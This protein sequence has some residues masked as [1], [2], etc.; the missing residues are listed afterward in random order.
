MSCRLCSK[1]IYFDTN[2]SY[3][4]GG[5]G[6]TDYGGID[7]HNVG[8][9]ICPNCGEIK[10]PKELQGEEKEKFVFDFLA[11]VIL[12]N[13][14]QVNDPMKLMRN[15]VPN[16]LEVSKITNIKYSKKLLELNKMKYENGV[17]SCECG[18]KLAEGYGLEDALLNLSM[19]KRAFCSTCGN[20]VKPLNTKVEEEIPLIEYIVSSKKT[21]DRNE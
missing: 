1:N 17:L 8:I 16:V 4:D 11:N 19:S 2:W 9:R 6:D 13:L 18:E 5:Y 15:V 12:N 10:V 20:K 3:T 14:K 21:W 7:I